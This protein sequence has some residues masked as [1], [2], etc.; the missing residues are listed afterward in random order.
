MLSKTCAWTQRADAD[1]GSAHSAQRQEK[2]ILRGARV[3]R[4]ARWAR[5]RS[6]GRLVRS[7]LW[8]VGTYG[9]TA[10]G[11]SKAAVRAL[12]TSA[13][14]SAADR[15][16]QCPASDIALG[17]PRDSHPAVCHRLEVVKAW[18]GIWADSLTCTRCSR[19][20]GPSSGASC[21]T[22]LGGLP[23]R[24]PS[25]PRLLPCLIFGGC[26]SS[27]RSGGAA[28]TAPCSPSLALGDCTE[29]YSA[30]VQPASVSINASLA[31]HRAGNG[32][33][34]GIGMASA[35]R[36]IKWYEMREMYG[37]AA[38]LETLATG[39]AWPDDRCRSAGMLNVP[40]TCMRCGVEPETSQ[41]RNWRC[42]ANCRVDAAVMVK[43]ATLVP[44]ALKLSEAKAIL[45]QRRG[46]RQRRGPVRPLLPTT[47]RCTG[48][49]TPEVGTLEACGSLMGP[50]ANTPGAGAEGVVDRRLSR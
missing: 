22:P 16:G 44:P 18:V 15:A 45:W 1:G 24:A 14:R 41:H 38:L 27:R 29:L 50:E 42:A 3:A 4:L 7:N 25:A 35:T 8:P 32:A 5:G 37:Q 43:T 6:A 21:V 9:A 2:Q 12:T 31:R 19:K 26:R 13:A 30:I 40:D 39:A 17:L 10:G 49:A 28:L 20:L 34:E 33:E 46:S 47:R 36:H 23:L 11:L 48:E